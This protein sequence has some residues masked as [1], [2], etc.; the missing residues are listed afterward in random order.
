MK[1]LRA[2]KPSPAMVVALIALF[3]ALGGTSFAA[4]ALTKNSVLSKHIR[5]GQVKRADLGANAVNSV[6][7]LDASLLAQDFAAGQLPKGEKGDTG[8]TGPTAGFGSTNLEANP[9]ATPEIT[10]ATQAVT[11][12]T[13][14]RLL[15]VGRFTRSTQCI[16]SSGVRYGLY[17][18]GTPVPGSAVHRA[19]SPSEPVNTFSL[20]GVTGSLSAGDHS[21]T[22]QLDCLSSDH[23][24]ASHFTDSAI[25]AVLLGS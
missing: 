7:V 6:K 14:G 17:V 2:H 16:G 1:L 20:E 19:A 22:I 5:N 15:V 13:S 24:G 8:A 4:V 18:D 11:L 3:L 23:Q 10:I 21:L 25:T 12:P 9:S